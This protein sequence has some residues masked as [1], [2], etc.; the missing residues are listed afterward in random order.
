LEWP[1]KKGV[2]KN[3]YT[4]GSVVKLWHEEAMRAEES[5]E[6]GEE[7]GGGWRNKIFD[8]PLAAS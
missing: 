8:V 5:I 1:P 3:V 4:P 2:F 6:E 7:R